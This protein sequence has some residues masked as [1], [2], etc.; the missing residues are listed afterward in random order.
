MNKNN[1]SSVYATADYVVKAPKTDKKP[2]R[3]S[4]RRGGDLRTG[5]KK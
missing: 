2:P 1:I 4:I 3:S 5:G